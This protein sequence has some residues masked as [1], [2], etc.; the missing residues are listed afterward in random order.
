MNYQLNIDVMKDL[1]ELAK[2]GVKVPMRAFEYAKNN[3]LSEYSNMKIA[4]IS[5]LL[6]QLF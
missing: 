6:I 1:T 4:D 5:D 3:D 2:I